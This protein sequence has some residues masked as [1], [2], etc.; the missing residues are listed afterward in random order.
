MNIVSVLI[1]H[2]I[3]T[4][5]S[6]APAL[7]RLTALGSWQSRETEVGP[8]NELIFPMVFSQQYVNSSALN[9]FSGIVAWLTESKGS[10]GIQT[11]DAQEYHMRS[12]WSAHHPQPW[13]R[14]IRTHFWPNH[15][16]GAHVCRPH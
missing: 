14:H 1:V 12:R 4:F 3:A 13:F 10:Q 16:A 2:R 8:G 11:L 5:L 6:P 15:R 7:I 9:V